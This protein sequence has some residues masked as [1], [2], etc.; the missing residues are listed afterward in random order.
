MSSDEAW[1]GGQ[2]VFECYLLFLD[3]FEVEFQEG[4][5]INE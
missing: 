1:F 3:G 2:S 4:G 5:S